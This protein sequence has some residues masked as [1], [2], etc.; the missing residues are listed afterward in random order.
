MNILLTGSSGFTGGHLVRRL[1]AEGHLVW[2]IDSSPP[3]AWMKSLDGYRHCQVNLCDLNTLRQTISGLPLEVGIHT[4]A[5]QPLHPHTDLAG[6]VSTNVLGTANLWTVAK[7]A[8][9]L[10][11]V[12]LSSLSVYGLPERLPVDENHTTQPVNSYGL[13]KLHA[14]WLCRFCALH[15][16]FHFTVLRC[17]SIFGSGQ[18]MPGFIQYLIQTLESNE[19]VELFSHGERKYDHVYV[20]DLIAAIRL[21]LEYVKKHKF[22]I[23]NIGGGDP[24]SSLELAKMIQ[25]KLGSS[26]KIILRDHGKPPLAH[27]AYMDISK[28]RDN[29]G[30]VPHRMSINLDDMLKIG[31]HK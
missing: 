30:F 20:G 9:I 11:W 3:L 17:D 26:G 1:I 14:E 24:A 2:G 6:F 23:F 5:K 29:L 4:A 27:D 21:A 28:A 8:H 18:N 31:T 10:H 7:E 15:E 16:G 22:S 12:V 25:A 13:S 19:D